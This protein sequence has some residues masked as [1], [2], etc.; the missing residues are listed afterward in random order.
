MSLKSA[1][2]NYHD[3]AVSQ[4]EA[5]FAVGDRRLA[6]VLYRAWEL[7]CLL[8]GWT[9]QFRYDLWKQAFSDCGLDIAFYAH[10]KRGL[11]EL[12][13]WDHIDAGISKDFLR[14]EYEKAMHAQTTRDCRKGCNGC[15][16]QKLKGVCRACE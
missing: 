2:F 3:S 9:E 16:L 8:D 15:G 14:R 12:L 7:G 13:P 1:H 5:C 10:R 11:D 6:R 4:M